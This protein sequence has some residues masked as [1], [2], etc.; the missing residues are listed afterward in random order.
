MEEGW[1]LAINK[2]SAP[3]C[4]AQGSVQL[5]RSSKAEKKS[6]PKE[7]VG[8]TVQIRISLKLC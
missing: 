8:K 5:E 4:S 1:I 6:L 7:A 3:P 2:A